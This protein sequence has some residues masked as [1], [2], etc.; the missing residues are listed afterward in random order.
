MLIYHQEY[1]RVHSFP[2]GSPTALKYPSKH[3]HSDSP[4]C[5][6]LLLAG[7]ERQIRFR[8]RYIP[9]SQP[10]VRRG[11]EGGGK[12]EGRAEERG[13]QGDRGGKGKKRTSGK[14]IDKQVEKNIP[15]HERPSKDC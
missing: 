6:L 3:G 10:L 14:W 13:G 5:V 2:G 1:V 12:G 15:M 7:Q 11:W 9:A 4:R 8:D